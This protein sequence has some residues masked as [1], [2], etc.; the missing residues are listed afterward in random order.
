[1]PVMAPDR[2]SSVASAPPPEPAAVAHEVNPSQEDAFVRGLTETF[3]GPLG[4]HAVQRRSIDRIWTPA[5]I[6][7]LLAI[8]VLGLHW[9]QKSPCMDGAWANNEQYSKFCY[10]DVLALYYAEHLN[11]GA[12]PYF[13]HRVEYPVLTGYF[14]GALGLPVHSLGQSNPSLNQG[15]AFY[16]LNALVLSAFAV[17][18]IAVVGALR[19]RRPWDAAMFALAPAILVTATV[20]WDFFAIGLTAFFMYAFARR[21]PIAA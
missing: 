14:M 21:W 10:T 16:N 12:V 5:R 13:D 17:A 4:D 8:L 7:I 2:P 1:M 6:V 11:E 15:Q 9:I 18:A 20:N 19:R 3:G